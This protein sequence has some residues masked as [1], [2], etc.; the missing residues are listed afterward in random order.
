M[1]EEA[2]VRERVSLNKARRQAS[3]GAIIL[4]YAIGV[5][6]AT[7]I[8]QAIPVAGDIARSF[9]LSP[10]QG[11][12]IIS[13]PSAV[14]ALGAIFTGWLVDRFGD[15][16]FLVIGCAIL[17]LGDI[18]VTIAGS[19]AGL[20]AMRIV[21]GVGYVGIAVAA[22]AMITRTTEGKR[23]TSALTLWSSFVPM[24]FIAPILLAAQLAGSDHWPWAF[25]GHGFVLALLAIAALAFLPSLKRERRAP[26]RNSGIGLVLRSRAPYL[27]GLAFACGAFLQTGVASALPHMLP[28]RFG[29][30]PTF[31]ASLVTVG[32]TLNLIGCLAVGP[33]LNRGAGA[34][35]IALL[36]VTLT[37]AG[38]FA[39]YVPG[40]GLTLVS[41]ASSLF[42]LGSGVIV[43]LWALLPRVAPSP[44][45]IG[46]T[47]GVVTQLVLWGVLFGPPAAFGLLSSGDWMQQGDS[48]LIACGLC[49]GLLWLV[50]RGAA[51]GHDT[52]LPSRGIADLTTVRG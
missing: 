1:L 20:Y 23:R 5:L 11:G 8:S 3:W 36:G 29:V 48:V 46:A 41:V 21:E 38:G 2:T 51:A 7:S 33:M 25:W 24:S 15:K 19:P 30:S 12:W 22:V 44:A 10:S 35:A 14:V 34:F 17:A 9:N 42:F 13:I 45:S 39:L 6:G 28:D 4:I 52:E 16:L 40:V 43:G 47:G 32:M 37:S 27:L 26:N 18:G 31:A 50:I 49:L